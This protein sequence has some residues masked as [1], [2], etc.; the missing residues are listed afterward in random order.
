MV[1]VNKKGCEMNRQP[2]PLHVVL[3]RSDVVLAV[4]W[5][6][7]FLTLICVGAFGRDHWFVEKVVVGP[8]GVLG[9]LWAS[10]WLFV[11]LKLDLIKKKYLE[12]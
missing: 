2:N 7:V 8:Y 3:S 5:M 1:S 10:V 11:G 12:R 9:V 4:G 6:V